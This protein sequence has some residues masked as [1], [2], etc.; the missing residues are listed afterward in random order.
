MKIAD[1]VK[2]LQDGE[3]L[4]V[5]DFEEYLQKSRYKMVGAFQLS[6]GMTNVQMGY[7]AGM[8]TGTDYF[9]IRLRCVLTYEYCSKVYEKEFIKQRA[10]YRN[11]EALK[12]NIEMFR[13]NRRLTAEER[14]KLYSGELKDVMSIVGELLKKEKFEVPTTVFKAGSKATGGVVFCQ[15]IEEVTEE[16]KLVAELPSRPYFSQGIEWED[17]DM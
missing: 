1:F 2:R 16:K 14:T 15:G 9:I 3:E 6:A 10:G 7:Y 5:L 17:L 11:I 12:K 4:S 13:K 8:E